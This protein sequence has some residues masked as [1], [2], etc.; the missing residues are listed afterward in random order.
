MGWPIPEAF[1]FGGPLRGWY[2]DQIESSGFLREL[3]LAPDVER[4]LSSGV[5]VNRLTRLLN[6]ATWHRVH[7]EQAWQPSRLPSERVAR[8]AA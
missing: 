2:R 1:W 3:G 8:R 6:L 7:V 4:S 5:P